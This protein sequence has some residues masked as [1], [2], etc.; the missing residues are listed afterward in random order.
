M[1]RYYSEYVRY[2]TYTYEEYFK[3]FQDSMNNEILIIS[4]LIKGPMPIIYEEPE[5]D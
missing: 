4:S 5:E 2:D 3:V 1:P